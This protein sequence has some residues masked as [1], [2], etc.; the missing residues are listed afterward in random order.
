MNG[1]M[2]N[3]IE[4]IGEVRN[5]FFRANGFLPNAIK[6]SMADYRR[7]YEKT[8][9]I[10]CVGADTILGLRIV[11]KA[12]EMECAFASPIVKIEE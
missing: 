8:E 7:L 9:G 2:P 3:I 6:M 10:S 5:A 11:K 4:K 12:G 1:Q